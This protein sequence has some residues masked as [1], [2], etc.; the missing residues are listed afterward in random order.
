MVGSTIDGRYRVE[1]RIGEGGMGVVY[2][3]SHVVLRKALAIKVMRSEQA[4]D[5]EVVQRFVQEAQSSSAI[6]HPNIIGISDFGTTADGSVYFAMEFLEG[7][8]LGKAMEQGPLP[9]ARAIDVFLQITSALEAAHQRGIVHRDLKPDNIF[10]V[11]RGDQR[12][13]VKILDF[14]IAKVKN[15]AAKITRTGMVFGTPHYM[16]PEQ[17]AGQAVDQRSDIY[18]LGVIMFQVFA[19]QLPFDAESYMGVMTK[20]M[21][22]PPPQPSKIL[23]S[24][25]GPIED[26][27]LM[28]LAKKPEQRYQ[29]MLEIKDDLERVRRGESALAS[30]RAALGGGAL[31]FSAP[32]GQLQDATSGAQTLAA[33]GLELDQPSSDTE[34][35]LPIKKRPMRL[36][37]AIVGGLVVAGFAFW[38]TS[39]D[40]PPPSAAVANGQ[41]APSPVARTAP[42]ESVTLVAAPKALRIRVTPDDAEIRVA[43]VVAGRGDAVVPKPQQ[44]Q[45]EVRVSAP[46]YRPQKLVLDAQSP[47]TIQLTLEVEPKSE[48]KPASRP[49][50]PSAASEKSRAGSPRKAGGA[51]PAPVP[52]ASAAKPVPSRRPGALNDVVDPWQ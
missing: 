16:S 43:G 52:A 15:A 47:D 18:S 7:Q 26:I 1:A 50:D 9:V 46:G 28:A 21:F 30:Q 27:I 20:H 12:D 37:P 5:A 49:P 51:E 44:N 31:A 22:D 42:A 29:S 24:L 39:R 13:F 3:A 6:G 35:A 48:P 14:G 32:P 36:V 23:P 19:G 8:T 33:A 17:A 2:R 38:A 34:L 10:L 4:N 25:R 45:T 40:Q 11:Q 41:P